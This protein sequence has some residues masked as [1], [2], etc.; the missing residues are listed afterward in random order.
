M[1]TTKNLGPLSQNKINQI[2]DL[3]MLKRMQGQVPFKL[4]QKAMFKLE[5]G[6]ELDWDGYM[7]D[8][9]STLGS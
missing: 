3:K 5:R 6:N 4:P 8:W 1:K 2:K 7:S 9:I